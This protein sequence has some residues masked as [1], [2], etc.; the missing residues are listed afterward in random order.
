MTKFSLKPF[1]PRSLLGRSLLILVTPVIL[2][3]VIATYIFFD[4]LWSNMSARLSYAVAGEIALV[5]ELIEDSRGTQE[6]QNIIGY[7]A[8]NLDLLV[9]FEPDTLLA[10]DVDSK[11]N[12]FWESIVEETLNRELETVLRRPFHLD[13]NFDKKWTHVFVQ[14]NNGVMEISLPQRRLFSSSGYIFLLWM[15]GSSAILLVVAIIFMRN[16]V[17]PIRKL[18]AAAERFGKGRDVQFFKP[19]GAREVRQAAQAFIDMHKRIKRQIE[20]RTTMLAGVSHDLRT[21]LTRLKLELALLPERDDVKAMQ[22]DILEMERMIEGYL[23]FVRGAGDEEM[24]LADINA[25]LDKIASGAARQGFAVTVEHGGNIHLTARPLALERCHVNIVDNAGQYA[26]NIDNSSQKTA[27][28]VKIFIDDDGPGIPEHLQEDVFRPFYR[29]D[30][31]RNAASGGVGL[32]L[33]IA[34]DIIHG[35]GGKIKLGKSPLG[36]LRV[37]INLPL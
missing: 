7:S 37:A 21:P 14:L 23:D 31:S 1:L 28:H 35:H 17:R 10:E 12:L 33:P 3:Q 15:T 18:A 20:Q 2:V 36:G 32:G 26:K 25:M 6:F 24:M 29:V 27:S 13:V 22:G 9:R 11:K 8:Q 16:Q 30:S 4:R 34:M 5:A 19:E